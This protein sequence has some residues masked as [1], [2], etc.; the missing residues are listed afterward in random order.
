MITKLRPEK[1]YRIR[2]LKDTMFGDSRLIRKDA[3]LIISS[4]LAKPSGTCPYPVR[5][6]VAKVDHDFLVFKREDL[7]S[8]FIITEEAK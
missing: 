7:G 6:W 5:K 8:M 3:T 1:R 4:Y 2:M